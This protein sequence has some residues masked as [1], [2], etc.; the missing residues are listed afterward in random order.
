MHNDS[1]LCEL[2]RVQSIE[3]RQ[4][5]NEELILEKFEIEDSLCER[6]RRFAVSNENEICKRCQTTLNVLEAVA[7]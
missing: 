4:T 3:L 2:L 5:T 7:N 1:Y 6:C